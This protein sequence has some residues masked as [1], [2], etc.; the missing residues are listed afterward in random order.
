MRHSQQQCTVCWDTQ[1]AV[2]TCPCQQC[3]VR[4]GFVCHVVSSSPTL[5]RH[6][7]PVCCR[8]EKAA[9]TGCYLDVQLLYEYLS[10]ADPMMGAMFPVNSLR[11][12]AL[13]AARTP[14]VAM[15]DVDL[16]LSSSLVQWLK[17]KDK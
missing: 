12:F 17:G 8:T 6:Q 2:P 4:H 14:L 15:I 10:A 1:P 13:V 9:G 5:S 16:L 11:N 3:C 7:C